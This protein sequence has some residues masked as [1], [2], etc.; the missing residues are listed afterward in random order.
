M[1][2]LL[3]I[4][5]DNFI[6]YVIYLFLRAAP[7]PRLGVEMQLQLPVYTTATAMKDLS[8]ICGLH[9]SSWQCW[10][11]NPLT[12]ARDQTHVLTDTSWVHYC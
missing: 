3:L 8:F 11:L 4:F 7:V 1:L 2:S 12:E 9:H 10:I 6:S 5:F